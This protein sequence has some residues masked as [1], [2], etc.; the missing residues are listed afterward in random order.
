MTRS[1]L[2]FAVT[3]IVLI[4]NLIFGVSLYSDIVR[5]NGDDQG[6][7]EMRRFAGVMRLIRKN[8]VDE[9]KVSYGELISGALNG[10]L[11]ALDRFSSYI[12]PEG[13]QKMREETEGE[14]GGIGVVVSARDNLL[15]VVAPMEGSPGMKAGIKAGDRIIQVEGEDTTDMT[16]D[17]AVKRIKG[18]PGTKIQLTVFRPSTEQAI[19]FEVERAIIEIAT[20]KDASY[21]EPG[22]AYI[23]VTQFNEKTSDALEDAID[24][25]QNEAEMNG[26]ILDLRNNPGGLLTSAI[27]VSSHFVEAKKLIVFTEGRPGTQ[28]DEYFSQRGAKFLGIPMAILINEGSASAAEI[29]AGCLQDYERAL[30]IGETSFGKGSVQ[31]IIEQEDG[32]AVRLTTAKYYTPS[33]R[34]IHEKG[35]NPDI[36][37]EVS[38]EVSA[39]LY[40]QRTRPTGA[41]RPPDSQPDL[42]DPQLSRALLAVQGKGLP[43][44]TGDSAADSA[45]PEPLPERTTT[46]ATPAPKIAP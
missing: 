26:L 30:L 5:E 16:L 32:S 18:K 37:V 3:S 39:Q 11:G 6:Y 8:Y 13:Y 44:P 23:R 35:I 2:I 20:V 12:P 46:P 40:Q 31:S 29:V 14:F 36:L 10:M 41:V 19:D 43:D 21:I 7:R 24:K 34:V 42:E 38:D 45:T 33:R 17:D 25:L 22:L 1:R 28:R 4:G 9:E 27:E 15:T